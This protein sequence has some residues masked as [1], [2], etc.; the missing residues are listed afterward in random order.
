M[1]LQSLTI[2]YFLVAAARSIDASATQD[3]SSPTPTTTD[4]DNIDLC[5]FADDECAPDYAK[6]RNE[7]SEVLRAR[8]PQVTNTRYTRQPQQV[9]AID[10]YLGPVGSE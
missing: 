6:Y 5:E 4:A 1:R 2:V 3:S 8:F 9:L 10:R 7:A